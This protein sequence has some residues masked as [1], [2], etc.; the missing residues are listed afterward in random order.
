MKILSLILIIVSCATKSGQINFNPSNSM[1]LDAVVANIHSAGCDSVLVEKSVY[2][3]TKI[4]CYEYNGTEEEKSSWIN[5]DYFAIAFGT[6]IP[7]DV[8]P[9]CTDPFVVMTVAE[10]D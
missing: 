1:C 4:Y 8:Q 2:G 6:T 9:I 10:R 5:N 7:S 3:I